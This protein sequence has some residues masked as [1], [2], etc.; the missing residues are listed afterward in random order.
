MRD[1]ELGVF[2][3]WGFVFTLGILIYSFFMLLDW[4]TR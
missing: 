1:D 4:I 3:V 2:L